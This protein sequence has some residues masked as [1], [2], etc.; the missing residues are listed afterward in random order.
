MEID[1][2]VPAFNEEGYL[3]N[4]LRALQ[5]QTVPVRPIVVDNNST[6]QTATIAR[7]YG[8]DVIFEAQKG[9][10]RAKKTG[11]LST[12]SDLVLMTDADTVVPP[13]WAKLLTAPLPN[14]DKLGVVFSPALFHDADTLGLKLYSA[15]SVSGK[16]LVWA[17]QR[18]HY[19]GASCAFTA[20]IRDIMA[21]NP[22]PQA[23]EAGRIFKDIRAAGGEI[24]WIWNPEAFV[25]TSA[26]RVREKG[27]LNALIKRSLHL[28]T[29][30]SDVAYRDF[31]DPS[32][33]GE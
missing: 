30:R 11:L 9:I 28:A 22:H 7:D 24:K 12:R 17:L 8:V 4:C 15:I 31:Y 10:G 5:R 2:V 27:L 1:V 29:G 19:Q 26:R 14:P 32:E 21:S 33:R 20:P 23:G 6:D 13:N 16:F 25:Q 18:P 3:E